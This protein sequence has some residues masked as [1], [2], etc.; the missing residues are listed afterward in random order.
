MSTRVATQYGL[1]ASEFNRAPAKDK[2]IAR[3]MEMYQTAGLLAR[4]PDRTFTLSNSN[5]ASDIVTVGAGEL[6][7]RNMWDWWWSDWAFTRATM[8]IFK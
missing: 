3:L 2:D 4:R 8:E 1:G 5:R 7:T 6:M